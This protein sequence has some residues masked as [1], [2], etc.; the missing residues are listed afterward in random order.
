MKK[1]LLTL[2]A[3]ALL[4][5]PMAAQ[6]NLV[7][8]GD[9]TGESSAGNDDTIEGWSSTGNVWSGRVNVKDVTDDDLAADPDGALG[10]FTKY[11]RV[12]LYDWNSWEN[13]KLTQAIELGLDP[14]YTFSYVVRHQVLD[15]RKDPS[16]TQQPVKLW[17]KLFTSMDGTV[18]SD[19]EPIYTEEVIWNTGDDWISENWKKVTV[20][21]TV[22]TEKDYYLHIEA[23]VFG[24][25]GDD[26]Q[27]GEGQNK[28]YLDL[29]GFSLTAGES[30]VAELETS[31]VVS[32]K[33]YG[34]DGVE[35]AAPAKG[36]FVIEKST[37][38]N[39]QVKTAKKVTR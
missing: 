27:G 24:T 15:V 39:G 38:A 3:I 34:I 10:T 2:G 25:S 22:D 35:I 9:F 5:M 1:I 20:P 31:P 16:A 32:V 19:A 33:Y 30:G 21:V 26:D 18:A 12:A 37:L 23:G 28:V 7:L 14:S 4:A 11:C 17:V 29:T 8:N 36:A 6:D 13:K